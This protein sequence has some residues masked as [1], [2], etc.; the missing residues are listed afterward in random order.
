MTVALLALAVLAGLVL[1]SYLREAL[2]RAP[3]VPEQ[4]TW[5]PEIP[6]RYVEV[7]GATIRYIVAGAGPAL[8]LLHTLRTQLDM[9]QKLVLPLSR[10]FRVHALDYPGHGYSD[11]PRAEYT[12][13][14]FVEAVAG[15]LERLDIEDATLVGESIGA[16]IALLLA[17]RGNRRVTRVIAVNPYDYDA[18]RGIRRS[19]A[20]AAIL[21]GLT[22]VPVLGDTFMRLRQFEIEKRVFQ[23][24]VVRKESIPDSLL[25]EMYRV[26]ERPGHYR[27]F[28]S[29]IR[30]GA[31]WEAARREYGKIDRPVLLLYG[32]RDWSRTDER[33]RTAR[34][35]PGAKVMVVP[36]T[37]H[38]L[39]LEAPEFIIR[40]IEA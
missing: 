26:G 17:A 1:L 20:V 36:T 12:A 19:S 38:F 18:G 39:S 3:V 4:L 27:A 14:F 7:G 37:G 25:R 21:F 23:G 9:F 22:P 8:V 15:F 31:T 13:D 16:T 32:E 2:R 33:E 6:I 29:L 35:I 40:N 10:R 28:I 30:N 5:A 24:G 34:S 11:I